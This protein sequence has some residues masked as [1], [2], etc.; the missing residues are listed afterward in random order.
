MLTLCPLW[1]L[2][3]TTNENRR[4]ST[5]RVCSGIGNGGVARW[6]QRGGGL[7]AVPCADCKIFIV[8]SCHNTCLYCLFAPSLRA[9][10]PPAQ[11][12]GRPLAPDSNLG[13]AHLAQMSRRP[14]APSAGQ[15]P[16][17]PQLPPQ[18]SPPPPAQTPWD[19]AS[20]AVTREPVPTPQPR[21]SRAQ[22]EQ[23]T[24]WLPGFL[25]PFGMLL[26]RPS[27][28]IEKSSVPA[29]LP[30]AGKR[31]FTR[32]VCVCPLVIACPDTLSAPLWCPAACRSAWLGLPGLWRCQFL[33]SH[34]ALACGQALCLCGSSGNG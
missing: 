4:N 34:T 14:S 20:E 25:R 33:L 26:V 19:A 5:R 17:P 18:A 2:S 3:P 9:P 16:P 7:E 15:G 21:N 32:L 12:L 22:L 1:H 23:A 29:R 13:Q 27:R 30:P 8:C 11:F 24:Q 10:P 6:R 31:L 28:T